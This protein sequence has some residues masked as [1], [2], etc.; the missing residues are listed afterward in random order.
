MPTPHEDKPELTDEDLAYIDAYVAQNEAPDRLK[1]AA[2]KA[3]IATG[4]TACSC[5]RV[6]VGTPAAASG[7]AFRR[8]IRRAK[9]GISG[10]EQRGRTKPQTKD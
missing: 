1:V 2:D 7:A 5:E 8:R 6:F 10:N 4:R 3:L 9:T